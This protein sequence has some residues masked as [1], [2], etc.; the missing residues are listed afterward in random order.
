MSGPRGHGRP[1]DLT[2]VAPRYAIDPSDFS[3][4]EYVNPCAGITLLK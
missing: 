3:P 1:I 2:L 4:V